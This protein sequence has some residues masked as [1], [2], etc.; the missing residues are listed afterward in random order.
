MKGLASATARA[1][2][3]TQQQTT[4]GQVPGSVGGSGIPTP[5]NAA[6]PGMSGP[7]QGFDIGSLLGPM[8][9]A[10][11]PMMGAMGGGGGPG[12]GFQNPPPRPVDPRYEPKMSG[13][14]QTTVPI[15]SSMNQ[16]D[17]RRDAVGYPSS[18][19]QDDD[20]N[21]L[22]SGNSDISVGSN[23][24]IRTRSNKKTNKKIIDLGSF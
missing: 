17:T 3:M 6:Q 9:G 15:P 19:A 11:G 7:S 14:N 24:V 4:A 12:L 1:A 16:S 2:D 10:M 22:D 23:G 5:S 8:M 21:S 18:R 13:Y 20:L